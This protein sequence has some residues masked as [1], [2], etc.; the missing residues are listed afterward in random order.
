[1]TIKY[2]SYS[3]LQ[4]LVAKITGRI[5]A[6]EDKIF[7][8]AHPVGEIY[9]S[10]DSRNPGTLYGGTWEAWGSGR[11]P[12][13]VNAS[14]TDFATVEKTGGAKSVNLAHSHTV[15]SHN[16]TISH[17]HTV[18]SHTHSTGNHTLTTSEIPSHS[19]EVLISMKNAAGSEFQIRPLSGANGSSGYYKNLDMS[20]NTIIQGGASSLY[21]GSTG[22]GG[23]H[24]H[25]NTGAA[26]PA[27][28]GG[29]QLKQWLCFPW[30]KLTAFIR[31]KRRTTV[32]HLLY[33]EA[34]GVSRKGVRYA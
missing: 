24:N 12:I 26:S 15:N 33:V 21:S 6:V 22:G 8:S 25:G 14:D 1:M 4:T 13:G 18:N 31:S 32:H 11:V 23:A 5:D 10:T 29:V 19:H 28:G 9:L 2:L 30:Y 20:A 16:H 27:T 7:L 3:A 17:T 34:G